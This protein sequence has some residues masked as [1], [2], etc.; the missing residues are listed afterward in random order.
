MT[1]PLL[2]KGFDVFLGC[3][4]G[5]YFCHLLSDTESKLSLFI[6]LLNYWATKWQQT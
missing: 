1:K 6:R 3:F 5:V 4:L 2:S